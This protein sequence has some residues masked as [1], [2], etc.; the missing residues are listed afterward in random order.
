MSPQPRISRTT[1][2]ITEQKIAAT[3]AVPLTVQL[4]VEG[5]PSMSTVAHIARRVDDDLPSV[6]GDQRRST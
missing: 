1:Q 5:E 2:Q 6:A 4:A 3:G